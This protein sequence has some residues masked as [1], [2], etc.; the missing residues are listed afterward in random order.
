[1]A[2]TS[3][4]CGLRPIE[5]PYGNVRVHYYQAATGVA[6]YKYQ[7]VD[8]DSNGRV[9]AA[10]FGSNNLLV[11]SVVGLYDG[12]YGPSDSDYSYIPANP[13]AYGSAGLVTVAVADDPGQFFL[14]EEDTGGSALDAQA[15]NAG[16]SLTYTNQNSGG[17]AVSGICY[18]GLDRSVVGTGSNHQLRII[19]KWDKPDNAYGNYCKWIVSIALHRYDLSIP[20]SARATFV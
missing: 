19:K 20:E 12:N 7:P 1:M 3:S 10:T 5:Q 11:G 4:I 8:L 16:A 6:F 17:S 15:C 13:V 18:A 2:N 9:V 14:I